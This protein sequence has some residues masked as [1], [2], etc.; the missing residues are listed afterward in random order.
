MCIIKIQYD[1][2]EQYEEF[3]KYD[4]IRFSLRISKIL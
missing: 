3:N 4:V 1:L 2:T